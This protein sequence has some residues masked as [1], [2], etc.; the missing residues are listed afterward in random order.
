MRLKA[1]TPA[2]LAPLAVPDLHEST[3]GNPRFVAGT[4]TSGSGGELPATLAETILARC[5]SEGAAAY[6]VL[7]AASALEQPFDPEPL[8]ALLRADAAE[9]TE[10]LERLCGRRILR[11]DGVR[12]R[13]RYDL[14]GQVLLTSLSPARRRLFRRQLDPP[15]DQAVPSRLNEHRTR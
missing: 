4:I 6:R 1:L 12:F 8:A 3:G 13:F 15:G 14:V 5:Q 2:E 11:V 10:E 9:L 7:L